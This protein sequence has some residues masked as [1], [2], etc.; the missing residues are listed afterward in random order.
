MAMPRRFRVSSRE[1]FW[2]GWLTCFLVAVTQRLFYLLI[3]VLF[4]LANPRRIC[5][6]SCRRGTHRTATGLGDD[7]QVGYL[8]TFWALYPSSMP[9]R[10]FNRF[11]TH[12]NFQV[13]LSRV[14]SRKDIVSFLVGIKCFV[15]I[16]TLMRI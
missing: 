5:R 15:P 12:R 7:Q 3:F 10:G 14:W 8:K 16:D 4:G 13:F 9:P 2:L 11:N 1:G 6:L